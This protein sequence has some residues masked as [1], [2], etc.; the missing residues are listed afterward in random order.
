MRGTINKVR[1][2]L[3]AV[4]VVGSLVAGGLGIIGSPAAAHTKLSPFPT[5][6]G[7]EVGHYHTHGSAVSVFVNFSSASGGTNCVWAQKQTNRGT[8]TTMNVVLYRCSTGNPSSACNPTA[9]DQDP[10][11]WQFFAGPVQLTGTAGRC[12]MVEVFYQGSWSPL[13]GPVHCG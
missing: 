4:A 5:C 9:L 7:S 2:A 1:Q 3:L 12:I 8:A 13:I 6:A 10:G 11:A